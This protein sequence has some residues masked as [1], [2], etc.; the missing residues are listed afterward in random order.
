MS[1]GNQENVGGS[2]GS[3]LS[4]NIDNLGSQLR[5]NIDEIG[6]KISS[7]AS[8]VTDNISVFKSA[9]EP[10][11]EIKNATGIHR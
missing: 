10:K 8:S 7:K 11:E 4:N 3:K 9:D 1:K 5:T 6:T 2:F